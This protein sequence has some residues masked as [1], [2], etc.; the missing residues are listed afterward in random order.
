MYFKSLYLIKK[1]QRR[2]YVQPKCRKQYRSMHKLKT[3]GTLKVCYF[4]SILKDLQELGIW[5]WIVNSWTKV[6]WEFSSFSFVAILKSY[7]IFIFQWK[8][9]SWCISTFTFPV[10]FRWKER[11]K[12]NLQKYLKSRN[13]IFCVSEIWKFEEFI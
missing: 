1:L 12:D 8:H 7:S 4:S 13:F 2:T 11:N 10:F 5:P 9:L 6:P 3:Y